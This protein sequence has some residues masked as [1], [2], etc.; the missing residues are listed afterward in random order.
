MTILRNSDQLVLGAVLL[1]NPQVHPRLCFPASSTSGLRAGNPSLFLCFEQVCTKVFFAFLASGVG[2]PVN[3]AGLSGNQ[4]PILGKSV[5]DFGEIRYRLWGNPSPILRK[6]ATDFGEMSHR[7]WG[8]LSPTLGKPATD[9]GKLRFQEKIS[10]FGKIYWEKH[11]PFLGKT[12]FVFGQNMLR[13]W[14]AHAPFLGRTGS[15][16]GTKWPRFGEKPARFGGNWFA[17]GL[18]L[19]LKSH[20]FEHKACFGLDF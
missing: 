5:T 13:F 7:L 8:N 4:P 18:G 16:F 14:G 2:V 19:G 6:S 1:R 20:C 17:F 15:V 12:C 10:V 3:E 9:F 11:V